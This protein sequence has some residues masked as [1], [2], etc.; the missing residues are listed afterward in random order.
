MKKILLSLSFIF[1]SFILC[2]CNDTRLADINGVIWKEETFNIAAT[3]EQLQNWSLEVV[4]NYEDYYSTIV[5][6]DITYY[7]KVGLSNNIFVVYLMD[8]TTNEYL[9]FNDDKEYSHFLDGHYY[10]SKPKKVKNE[11]Y[12]YTF[13]VRLNTESQYYE[14]CIENNIEFPET[15][16]FYGYENK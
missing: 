5:V 11:E 1:L 16:T 10:P 12:I 9:Y 3:S 4:E 2:S 6:N 7:C 13:T 8:A 15:L 14:Y